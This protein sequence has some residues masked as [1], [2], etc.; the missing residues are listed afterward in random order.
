MLEQTLG[1]APL[2]TQRV[3]QERQR[4]YQIVD[5]ESLS[6]SALYYGEGNV[7]MPGELTIRPLGPN[8]QL[9]IKE[10]AGGTAHLKTR[11][12]QY[13]NLGS[14]EAAMLDLVLDEHGIPRIRRTDKSERK[15]RT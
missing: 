5:L 2:Q 12:G 13:Q 1:Y 15:G 9:H 7:I 11:D 6:A 14:Y 3:S 10:G 8:V 4:V